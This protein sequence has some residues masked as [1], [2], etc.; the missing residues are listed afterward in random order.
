MTRRAIIVA[1]I[2][3]IGLM[4]GAYVRGGYPYPVHRPSATILALYSD[5][6]GVFWLEGA[7]A[8]PDAPPAGGNL[9]VLDRG[10][11]KARCVF[12][13][14]GLIA[15]A[16]AGGPIV[17]LQ[18]TG[19]TGAVLS[20]ERGGQVV[21]LAQGLSQPAGLATYQGQA[22]WTE[23]RP[24]VA[25]HA[26]H[27]PATQARTILRAVPLTGQSAPRA[28]ACFGGSDGGFTGELL[29]GQGDRLYLVDAFGQ[30]YPPGWSALRAVPVSGGLPETLEV[31][32]GKQ[33]GLLTGDA[34][35]WTGVSEDA[36]DPGMAR[37]VRRVQ[38][39]GNSPVTLT[40]W[41]PT[42]GRLCCVGNRVYY[43]APDGVWPVP[44]RQAP[45]QLAA[46]VRAGSGQAVG[47]GGA[48]YE[49]ARI[50]GQGVVMRQP[51]TLWA[52]LRAGLRLR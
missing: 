46:R 33:T 1:L 14:G 9:F 5:T 7:V 22:F 42:I 12:A 47:F 32:R 48:V 27:L 16:G 30:A 28:L 23:T 45:P 34:L 4:I 6:R 41:L 52:R 26:R 21:T 50:A 8:A 40:D 10:R 44:T 25:P 43:G 51:V 15:A 31:G 17:A 20:I 49:A 19:D 39:P 3:L 13:Q 35:Y 36:G 37:C 29:G 24:A 38:L 11:G 18:R 2:V